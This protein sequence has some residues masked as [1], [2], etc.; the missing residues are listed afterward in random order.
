MSLL[1]ASQVL[2]LTL[3][4]KIVEFLSEPRLMKGYLRIP[5][6]SGLMLVAVVPLSFCKIV[7]ITSEN[8]LMVAKNL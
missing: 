6:P 1:R 7:F 2:A 3:L 5:T 8:L 4:P